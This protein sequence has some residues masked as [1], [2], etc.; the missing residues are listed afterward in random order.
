VS[1]WG[2]TPVAEAV[3]R[4]DTHMRF[5]KSGM[6]KVSFR[7][8]AR[9]HVLVDAVDDAGNKHVFVL[10]T[11]ASYSVLSPAFVREFATSSGPSHEPAAD[12][13]EIEAIG[14]HGAL[15]GSMRFV[16]MP[17]LRL[18]N[19]IIEQ[20]G[21]VAMEV[22]CLDEGLG[23]PISGILGY[24]VLSHI[25]TI[26]DYAE[27]EIVFLDPKSDADAPFGAPDHTIPFRLVHGA[28]IEIAGQVN[29]GPEMPFIYD[30]GSPRTILNAAAAQQSRIAFAPSAEDTS[31]LMAKLNPGVVIESGEADEL[32]FG[33]LPF[34]TPTLKR[35]D[36][37]VFAALGLGDVPAG[38]LGNDLLA[39]YRVGI[40]YGAAKL[41]IW[42][43]G[44]PE[45]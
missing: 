8:G 11:G 12:D 15:T 4:P 10:D 6:A 3:P 20:A 14:A 35:M 43:S 32:R 28:L 24:N 5:G 44:Q 19:L 1:E 2:D 9:N 29:G 39:G 34:V 21:A 45:P 17:T 16:A 41:R 38:L 27:S 18:G 33:T 7:R 42:K 37:P 26:V 13:R 30:I 23:E 40:D 22:P 36:L 25:M 31:A